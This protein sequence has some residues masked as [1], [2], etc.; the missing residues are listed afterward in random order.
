MFFV[1]LFC[2]CIWLV[3]ILFQPITSCNDDFNIIVGPFQPPSIFS[4]ELTSEA[5]VN[6]TWFKTQGCDNVV[7][8]R[9][10]DMYPTF[11]TGDEIYN[12]SSNYFLDTTVTIGNHYYYSAWSY[13]ITH[14]IYSFSNSQCNKLILTP[15]LFDIRDIT[16]IDGI[17]P[18]L[19]IICIVENVGGISSDITVSWLLTRVDTDVILSSGSDTFAVSGLSEKIYR[20]YPNTNYVGLCRIGYVGIW[21]NYTAT[22]FLEF[23]T[24]KT[25]TPGPTPSPP[26]PTPY[27]PTPEPPSVLPPYVSEPINFIFLLFLIC[28]LALGMLLFF[29][30]F[31]YR[32]YSEE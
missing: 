1:G 17:T 2:F 32:K 3:L 31:Y 14:N 15:S 30:F 16:I 8:R 12:G 26:G 7:I 18:S 20:I 5:D 11:F 27:H 24:T 13:N 23:T 21:N 9:R 4:C 22:T 25:D 19:D 6:I 10:Q 28:L 29:F